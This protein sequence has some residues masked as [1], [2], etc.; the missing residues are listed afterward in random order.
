MWNI[1]YLIIFN[2][3]IKR[4]IIY[5][6]VFYFYLCDKNISYEKFNVIYSISYKFSFFIL[7]NYKFYFLFANF[8]L[9]IWTQPFGLLLFLFQSDIDILYEKC[10]VIYSILYKF[11]VSYFIE[12][13][14]FLFGYKFAYCIKY[15]CFYFVELYIKTVQNLNYIN[16]LVHLLYMNYFSVCIYNKWNVIKIHTDLLV[17]IYNHDDYI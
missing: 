1:F 7:L 8:L 16:I 2:I 4:T 15:S 11:S 10:N 13:Y 9:T 6:L 12:L 5:W 14:I 3:A 17:L